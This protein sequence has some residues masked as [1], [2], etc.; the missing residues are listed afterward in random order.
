LCQTNIDSR[1]GWNARVVTNTADPFD[2]P[3]QIVIRKG[4]DGVN[5]FSQA[6]SLAIPEAQGLRSNKS[7]VIRPDTGID[8][9]VDG[10]LAQV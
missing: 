4:V 9:S 2:S 10:G 6:R 1:V 7:T 8:L 3:K 5:G